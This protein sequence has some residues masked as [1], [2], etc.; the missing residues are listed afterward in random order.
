MNIELAYSL[1]F[2][3]IRPNSRNLLLNVK[4]RDHDRLH[5]FY[6]V[7]YVCQ[8]E[9]KKLCHQSYKFKGLYKLLPDVT[10]LKKIGAQQSRRR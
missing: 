7:T 1:A 9:I 4:E 2:I 8:K 6:N 3:G 5:A 10:E